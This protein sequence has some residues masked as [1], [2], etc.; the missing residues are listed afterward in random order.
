MPSF[1]LSFFGGSPSL[2]GLRRTRLAVDPQKERVP[3]RKGISTSSAA[4]MLRTMK[5]AAAHDGVQALPLCEQQ[6]A[7]VGKLETAEKDAA[8]RKWAREAKN[9]SFGAPGRKNATMQDL[10][11]SARER[12]KPAATPSYQGAQAGSQAAAQAAQAGSQATQDVADATQATQA[13]LLCASGLDDKPEAVT[14]HADELERRDWLQSKAVFVV[15]LERRVAEMTDEAFL[16]WALTFD[17]PSQF[18]PRT[19]HGSVLLRFSIVSHADRCLQS[20][21]MPTSFLLSFIFSFLFFSFLP[22]VRPMTGGTSC[23]CRA[24]SPQWRSSTSPA[25]PRLRG[26]S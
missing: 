19:S 15:E 17:H 1:S 20:D 23:C 11:V 26:P 25:M 22:V 24:S 13:E 3:P 10:H 18:A 14:S 21:T 4:V 6:Q 2:D 5:N 7:P 9:L 8:A 12:R 16:T